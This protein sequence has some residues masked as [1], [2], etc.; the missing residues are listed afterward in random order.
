V[1]GILASHPAALGSILSDP[2]I[3]FREKLLSLLDVAEIF[4]QLALLRK[5]PVRKR[6]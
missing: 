4:Q 3:F 1:G 2:K 5:W 6:A